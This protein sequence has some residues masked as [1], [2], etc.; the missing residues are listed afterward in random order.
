MGFQHEDLSSKVQCC[1]VMHRESQSGG[2]RRLSDKR[3]LVEL[4]CGRGE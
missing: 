3:L 4:W 1:E 2:I